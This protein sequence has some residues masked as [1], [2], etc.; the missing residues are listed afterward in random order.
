MRGALGVTA[1]AVL[2]VAC[3]GSGGSGGNNNGGG[4]GNGAM[5][6]SVD[7][8]G[9]SATTATAA[10]ASSSAGSVYTITGTQVSGST[11]RSIALS[12]YNIA[13]PGTYPLGVNSTNFGGIGSIVDGSSSWT[14]PLSGVAGTVIVT[15]LTSS[16]IAGTFTF[17]AASAV[18]PSSTRAVTSGAFDLAITGT[19]GTLQPYQ[20]SS[21]KATLGTTAWIG[22]TIVVINKTGGVYAFGGTSSPSV[23][24]AGT[25][26]VNIVLTG[27]TGPGTYPLGPGQSQLSVTLGSSGYSSS[28]SGSSGSVV[29]TSVD[30]NRLKGTFSATLSSPGGPTLAVSGG[31]FDIGLGH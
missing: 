7:G 19:P 26:S 13:G 28:L 18:T 30:T 16:R 23:T 5:T 9:F 2:W 4:G 14:T 25:S 31:T 22:A 20:G 8:Q 3:G 17:T 12:L 1:A 29:V 21:M 15:S 6:A 27:V 10:A 11:A 24:G